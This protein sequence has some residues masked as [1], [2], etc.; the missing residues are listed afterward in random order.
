MTAGNDAALPG[1]DTRRGPGLSAKKRKMARA[2]DHSQRH[3]LNQYEFIRKYRCEDCGAVM[4]CDCDEA[5]AR[6]FLNHQIREGTELKSQRRVPVTIGFQPRV[7]SE[8]RGLP[9]DVAPHAEAYGSTSKI[10]RYYW[11]ELFFETMRRKA[12]W[13]LAHPDASDGEQGDAYVTFQEAALQ[14]IKAL[15]AA[16]PKYSFSE[17]SQA[18]ILA[19]Y[20][21]SIVDL[22]AP[23]AAMPTKGAV[24]Q[25]GDTVISPE[26]FAENWFKSEGW[27]VMRLESQPFHVL[28][29]VF[30]W[31]L[32]Q[33]YK[34]PQVRLVGFA[35]K[36]EDSARGGT[37]TGM[38]LAPIGFWQRGL[39]RA[40]QARHRPTF[41]R[42]QPR[43]SP[44]VAVRLLAP[45]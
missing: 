39:W 29:G 44:A 32:I 11:R 18:D 20:N 40:A 3:C 43:G 4:M 2:C 12:D 17:P 22:K 26:Q 36:T 25:D 16:R 35:E 23:Y 21:V 9:A 42:D 13:Q 24:I 27:N 10:K 33:D 28:F 38:G 34:D 7:C 15:H 14:T 5:F 45:L 6:K 41:P 8:C 31:R 37:R 1:N 30:F 19:R